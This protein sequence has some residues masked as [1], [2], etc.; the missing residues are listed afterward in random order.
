MRKDIDMHH[1]RRIGHGVTLP[2]RSQ[3][4]PRGVVAR[5]QDSRPIKLL[6]QASYFVRPFF[7]ERLLKRSDVEMAPLDH[8]DEHLMIFKRFEWRSLH[9][10]PH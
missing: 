9:Y 8:N 7:V 10:K 6:R 1:S 3:S 2:R 5:D 4:S